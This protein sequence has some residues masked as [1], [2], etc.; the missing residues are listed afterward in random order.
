MGGDTIAASCRLLPRMR[1]SDTRLGVRMD[2]PMVRMATRAQWPGREH[3]VDKKESLQGA[4]GA[5]GGPREP[6]AH[7]DPLPLPQSEDVSWG[8]RW[9]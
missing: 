1:G 6:P 3:V 4:V 9:P 5:A 2:F 8:P 7:S